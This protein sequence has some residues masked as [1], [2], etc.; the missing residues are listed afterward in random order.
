MPNTK[1]LQSQIDDQEETINEALEILQDAYTP[2]AT[3]TDLVGAVSDAIAVLSGEEV[4]ESS[5]E[6]DDGGE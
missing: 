2:E 4:E 6:E 1:E 3:R 5:E